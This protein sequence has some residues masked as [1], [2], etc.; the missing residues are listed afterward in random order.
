M[1]CTLHDPA[2]QFDLVGPGP[3]ATNPVAGEQYF[4]VCTDADGDT[5]V[6]VITYQPGVNVI[7]APTLARQAFKILPLDYPLPSTAPPAS[8][9]QLVGVRTWL[10]IDP[11]DYR[12]ITASVAVPG[13]E[14]TATATPQQV[15]W[16]MGDADHVVT[17]D[18]PGTPYA[19]AVPD[20]AQHT[21]CSYV[22]QRSGDV[23]VTAV[24]D[25]VVTWRAT[26]GSGGT[27]PT[28][29]RGTSFPLA[30]AQRQAIING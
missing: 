29:S 30:V 20:D 19:A 14:V 9:P 28:V 11:A 10:W 5:F 15:R 27:L 26:D 4:V 17:C 3:L 2:S 21:D 23:T 6:R 7:D 1:V 22:F 24:I 16:L 12:P 25:W 8:Q 13:L 18:G